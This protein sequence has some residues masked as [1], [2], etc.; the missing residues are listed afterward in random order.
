MDNRISSLKLVA[1][2]MVVMLHVSGETFS[3]FNDIW[4][5][6]GN[7]YDSLVRS[8]VPIFIMIAG[9]TLLPKQEGLSNF[10]KKRVIRIIPPLLLWS[11]FYLWWL[12]YNGMNTSNWLVAILSG[13]TMYH[14]WYF[15]ALVGLYLTIPILRRFHQSSTRSEYLWFL[16]TW[17]MVSS[18]IPTIQNLFFNL[19]CEGSI[20]VE[21]L[22]PY[23]LSYLSGYIG[24]LML[25]AFA[26]KENPGWKVG[27][28]IYLFASLFT[29]IGT[30]LLS[31]HFGKACQFFFV[32]L[33]PS[34]VV[35]AYGLFVAFMN[36]RAG[37]P[38]KIIST[39]ADCTLGAYGLHAFIIDPVSKISGFNVSMGNPWLTI[40]LTSVGV[41]LSSLFLIYIVRLIPPLRHVF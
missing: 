17:L 18:I 19:H 10:F 6:A 8:C 35:A 21:Q 41:F 36:L 24:Y 25:G 1:C 28:S 22:S 38:S 27:I 4:W 26:A 14:L 3:N 12:S 11:V 31:M 34:V 37:A 30:Y 5:L 20:S 33:S 7:V 29:S 23:H 15:Y 2:F 13:P 40:P 16:G 32:Y 9:A 39:L